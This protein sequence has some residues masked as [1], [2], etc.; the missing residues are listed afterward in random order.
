METFITKWL[1]YYGHDNTLQ[2]TEKEQ[3]RH[4]PINRY[5]DKRGYYQLQVV[6]V[7][8]TKYFCVYDPDEGEGKKSKILVM[9]ID[10]A[11]NRIMSL[12]E[13]DRPKVEKIAEAF[14]RKQ[15]AYEQ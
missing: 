13:E 11:N 7:E 4:V 6:N 1:L 9:K 15:P 2:I 5:L 10:T 3:S 8:G 12:S 14:L